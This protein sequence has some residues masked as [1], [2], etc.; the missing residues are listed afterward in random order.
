MFLSWKRQEHLRQDL[1][2]FV[3][4]SITRCSNIS[5]DAC[6]ANLINVTYKRVIRCMNI[7]HF[8]H[9]FYISIL[10]ISINMEVTFYVT[11]PLEK[12]SVDVL[13]RGTMYFWI[14]LISRLRNIGNKRELCS[15]YFD[16]NITIATCLWYK[17]ILDRCC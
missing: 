11:S 6:L 3:L 13:V 10:Y 15:S 1:K 7:K 17:S 14:W 4:S 2:I 5:F 16:K 12:N 8:N 9:T